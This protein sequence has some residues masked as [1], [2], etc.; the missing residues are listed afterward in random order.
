MARPHRPILSRELIATA[1][2]ELVDRDGR[3]T[4]PELAHKLGV[5][6]SSLYHHVDGRADIVEGI[7]G[8]LTRPLAAAEPAADWQ[9]AV[10]RW[11]TAYRDGFAAHPAAIPMLVGQTVGNPDTLAQYDRLAAILEDQAGLSG[12]DLLVAITMLDTL[13][14]GAAL[15]LAAPAEVWTAD[16]RDTALT[17]ALAGAPDPQR[18]R[19]RRSFE[20]QLELIIGSLARQVG[21][22]P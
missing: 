16:G 11:A 15:D 8:L 9:E 5:S 3:F 7:R 4:V 19:S 2:L 6:V 13:C 10:R 22:R 21:P 17:R 1:A 14:L 20:R 18:D 12:D